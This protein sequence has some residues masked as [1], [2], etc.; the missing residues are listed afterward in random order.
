MSLI[1]RIWKFCKVLVLV[2]WLVLL[3]LIGAKL[4]NQ[5]DSLVTV[6]LLAWVSPNVSLG[7]ALAV[8]FAGG[9][10]LG[11]LGFVPTLLALRLRIRRLSA[12]LAKAEQRPP[13]LPEARRAP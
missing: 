1:Q 5:N 11:L 13:L 8:A 9:I 4:A 3:L 12:K 7:L 10:G 6:N 2:V